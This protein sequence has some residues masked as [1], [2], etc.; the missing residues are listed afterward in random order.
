MTAQ[1]ARQG[2]DAR[3]STYERLARERPQNVR[4]HTARWRQLRPIADVD[5]RARAEIAQFCERKL[6]TV[7]ALDAMGARVTR[8]HDYGWCLAFAGSSGDWITAI[9]YRPLSGTSHDSFAE[10]GSVWVR[11]IVIGDVTSLDWL[12]AEGETDGARLYGLVGDRSA[13]LVLPAGAR[14]FRTEWARVIPRGATV[15]LCHDADED[16]DAGAE[17]AAQIIGAGTIR[18]R[19]PVEGGDWCDWPGTAD[20]FVKLARPRDRFEFASFADFAVRAFPVAE[21]LLGSPDKVFLA[22]GSLFMT[23]GSDGSGKST[24]TIDAIVH[25]AAGE[26]WLG[27]EVPR[28]VRCCL[29]ENEGPPGLFQRKLA[30]K[31]T[32]WDGA[33][34]KD[35]LFLYAAPWGEFTFADPKARAALSAYCDEHRIDVVA[36]NPTLGLGV[37]TSGRPDETQ[38]FVDWLTEC[39]L[40]RDRAFWLLHHENKQGQISG[41]WGRHPDTYALLQRDGNR[42]RTKLTWVKTRW[43][44]LDPD[45]KA[46]AL[47]WVIDG[48]GYAVVQLD[49][50]GATDDELDGRIKAYLADHQPASTRSV[51]EN[52]KGTNSRITARLRARFDSVPGRGNTV[53]WLSAADAVDDRVVTADDEPTR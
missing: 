20:E 32:A 42:Q 15:A 6:I 5:D 49:A 45:E 44:T 40:K 13:V 23:Y 7:E 29:V 34:A 37:G 36:A 51:H 47:E 52:V 22:A 21:P 1:D 4:D 43:A 39:G 28:P 19:P 12:I 8:H 14:T 18:V 31:L 30:A 48:Q 35:N 38:Q 25:L 11:P 33:D 17:D 53:L 3:S 24:F 27:I 46:V 9:K 2:T 16:G 26:N 10:L 41:D 50:A